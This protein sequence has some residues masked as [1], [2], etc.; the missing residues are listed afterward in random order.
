M[1]AQKN[2]LLITGATGFVGQALCRHLLAQKGLVV[3][4]ASD[5]RERQ[6]RDGVQENPFSRGTDIQLLI[7]EPAAVNK[8]PA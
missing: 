2:R 4:E 1:T 3:S 6:E 5:D 8:I 7:R